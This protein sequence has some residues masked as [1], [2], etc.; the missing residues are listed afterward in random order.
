MS[1]QVKLVNEEGVL[2][3]KGRNEKSE[4]FKQLYYFA[5]EDITAAEAA[6][7]FQRFLVTTP[8]Q[9]EDLGNLDSCIT[10][11]YAIEHSGTRAGLQLGFGFL[12]R[13][14]Y[15]YFFEGQ[16]ADPK[17]WHEVTQEVLASYCGNEMGVARP[18]PCTR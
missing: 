4:N 17:W 11:A 13:Y 15:F 12:N 5:G 8:L 18:C 6:G 14:I 1:T 3:L 9:V 10:C 16:S 7:G 2:K